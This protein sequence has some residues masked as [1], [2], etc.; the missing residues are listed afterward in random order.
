MELLVVVWLASAGLGAF[1]VPEKHRI[2]GAGLGFLFGPLGV[3]IAVLAL[4]E[5]S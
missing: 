5:E 1:L 4:K 3:L 2:A